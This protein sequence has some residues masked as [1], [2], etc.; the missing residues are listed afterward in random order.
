VTAP[1]DGGPSIEAS[2]PDAS[3]AG[4]SGPTTY[5][6]IGM[7]THAS[8]YVLCNAAQLMSL[9]ATQSAWKSSYRLGAD[10]D[11]GSNGPT[12]SSPYTMIGVTKH[13]FTGTFDGG[14]HVISNVHV[15]MMNASDVGL[16]GY[17]AGTATEIR[18]LNVTGG[19]VLA[20]QNVGILV[21]RADNGAR[22]LGCASR[23]NAKADDRVG[24]LVGSATYGP[25]ISSSWSSATVTATGS[26]ALAG[27][28]VGLM[29]NGL[30]IFN[31]FAAGA[32]NGANS[33]GGLVGG[34]DSGAV[35]NSFSSA[36]VAS[37]S[38]SADGVGGFV[39][40]VHG[41]IFQNCF[42]TGSVMGAAAKTVN[43]FAGDAPYGTYTNNF[44]S[45][46]STCQTGS[47]ACP[48]DPD[49]KAVALAQLQDKT[50]APMST[51]DFKSTWVAASGGYPTLGST[52]FDATSWSAGAGCSAHMTDTPFAGGDGTPDRPYL[53]CSAAQFQQLA[54]NAML[55][56]GVAVLQM[57]SIDFSSA[58]TLAPIGTTASPF[59]G[60]YD[61]NG[62]TLSKF[63]LQ[64]DGGAVG[65]FGTAT[66]SIVR[67]GAVGG[68]VTGG[69]GAT[70]T[71]ILT[72]NLY[73]TLI[74]TYAAGGSVT[75]PASVAGLGNVHSAVSSY[76]SSTVKA[77]GGSAGGLTAAGGADGL[78]IDVFASSNVTASGGTAYDITPTVNSASQV[79]DAYYDSSK[80]SGCT[81]VDG[82]GQA[83][84]Y[85]YTATNAPMSKWDF[86]NVWQAN[87][88]AFPTL[89]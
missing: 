58:G 24:G 48:T 9:A 83:T 53:V 13:P 20:Y 12:S 23:G 31:S 88:G 3:C 82:T 30:F 28:L 75:G 67:V 25:T 52:L 46:G 59:I 61:G 86:D 41:T 70:K 14:G 66:G 45:S 7:G 21:G 6:A 10:I 64:G 63:T 71:G 74:D 35:Y 54:S 85:F 51:W 69:S 73:G 78:V 27:G 15:A 76:A 68:T 56:T 65:L 32:V 44:V 43:A 36:A 18:S 50:Q 22:I 8:P 89:R 17:I 60:I 42:A 19:D 81:N 38:S 34:T 47:G 11:L 79:T 72:G 57:A 16:F 84:S 1:T 29:S 62:K 49:A 2:S 39:G 77:T 55:R 87:S 4:A 40:S 37:T 5:N 26:I 33:T 80:C